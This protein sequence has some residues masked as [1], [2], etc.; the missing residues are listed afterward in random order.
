MDIDVTSKLG[1]SLPT[2]AL[3][4]RHFPFLRRDS[5]QETR[6][7]RHSMYQEGGLGGGW[8]GRKTDRG[9]CWVGLT[10]AELWGEGSRSKQ[11]EH[12]QYGSRTEHSCAQ[13]PTDQLIF[14]AVKLLD[15]HMNPAMC[16]KP[17]EK[18]TS[19]ISH[20]CTTIWFS[21]RFHTNSLNLELLFKII[22]FSYYKVARVYWGILGNFFNVNLNFSNI[23]LAITFSVNFQLVF[24]LSPHMYIVH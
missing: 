8:R 18:N 19:N 13:L 10:A 4:L 2:Q 12:G 6:T 16:L 17:Q 11:R 23:P 20:L 7:N 24:F 22:W 9:W 5:A 3:A 1:L 14:L 15:L 21:K